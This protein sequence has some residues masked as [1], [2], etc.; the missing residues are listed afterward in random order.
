MHRQSLSLRCTL[1]PGDSRFITISAETTTE[2]VRSRET[3]AVQQLHIKLK[4]AND[5]P[6]QSR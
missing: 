4:T 1:G 3:P 5:R 6:R 2:G